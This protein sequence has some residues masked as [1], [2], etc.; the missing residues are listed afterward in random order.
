MQ[1]QPPPPDVKSRLKAS[2]DAMAPQYNAWTQ[3]HNVLRMKYL[4]LLFKHCPGLDS[5]HETGHVPSVL[6][7]GCGAGV[8][9]LPTLMERNKELR[10][11]A[12]DISDTQIN[13]AKENLKGL[14]D[15]IEFVAGDMVEVTKNIPPNAYTAIIALYSI[16]HLSQPDQ[17][18][19]IKRIAEMLE[20]GG[21]FL[22][23]FGK[24]EEKGVVFDTWLDKEGWMF[25]SGM[26]VEGTVRALEESGMEV[27][28]KVVEEGEDE[29]FLWVIARKR[30]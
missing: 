7:L 16:I 23:S 21:C 27:Q 25:W 3:K 17:Q 5:G 13:L 18:V 29:T 28:V 1:S 24:D 30:V 14:E 4:D 15:N 26:G 10:I 2:Y 12:T 6:E 19:M 11:L 20:P 8:P 9:V 22:A